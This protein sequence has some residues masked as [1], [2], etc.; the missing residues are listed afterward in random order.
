MLGLFAA[1]ALAS[2][3]QGVLDVVIPTMRH[4]QPF[5]VLFGLTARFGPAFFV[6]YI[7]V[8]NMG[9]ACLVPGFGFVAARI[10]KKPANRGVIG[11][12]L[13]GAVLVTLGVAA[14]YLIRTPERFN[15]AVSIPLFVGESVSVLAMGVTAALEL[16]RYVP[17]R[18]MGWSLVLPLRTVGMVALVT[19]G[20]LLVLAT[21]EAR[22][23]LGA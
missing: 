15:M 12:L 14:L 20:L 10:E 22:A 3:L 18:K 11:A 7:F 23:V 4:E 9:L 16:R 19:A 2:L 5:G 8:H 17:T 21:V 13:L 1:L 6:A